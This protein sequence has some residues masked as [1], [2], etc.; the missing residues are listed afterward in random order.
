MLNLEEKLYDPCMPDVGSPVERSGMSCTISTHKEEAVTRT[1]DALLFIFLQIYILV[2]SKPP[3]PNQ[4]KPAR[5]VSLTFRSPVCNSNL[6]T[7]SL[8]ARAAKWRALYPLLHRE[9]SV[10]LLMALG[11]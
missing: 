4:P 7:S 6:T 5:V 9:H 3:P 10:K 2:F 8:P 11:L 1:S